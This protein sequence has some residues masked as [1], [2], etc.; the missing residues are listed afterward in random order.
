MKK[1]RFSGK[2]VLVTG[3]L[4]FIGSNLAIRLVRLGA[5]V[6]VVDPAIEGCGGND[7]NLGVVSQDVEILRTSI[8]EPSS[9][10]EAIRASDVIFNLA[11]EISHIHSMLFPER[12]LE[13]NTRAQLRF[14][15]A[16]VETVPGVRILYAGTRQVYG[17]PEYLPVDERHPVNPVDFNG[18]HK[19]AATM[20]HLMLSRMGKLDAVVLR[21]TNVYGPRMALDVP[22]QGF[23][24]TF[25]RKAL[26]GQALEIYGDGRQLRDPLY[27]DDAVD[28]MLAAASADSLSSRSYNIGGPEPLPL[29][30]IAAITSRLAGMPRPALMDFPADRK[31]IDIGSYHTDSSLIAA[32]LGWKPR[33]GFADGM[34][35]TIR[36]YREN[37]GRYLDSSNPNPPCK[38]THP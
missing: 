21:F 1:V 29:A 3:G 4:G 30:G 5:R 9:F 18:V 7:F 20:Y 19:Y 25:L 15:Q 17:I 10:R 34:E 23:L 28:A 38:L 36:Y 22:C 6:T 16:C 24:S 26:T 32:H 31:A 37:L 33:V 14:L 13:I 35:R 2:R 27:V 8:G 11:G 12:D